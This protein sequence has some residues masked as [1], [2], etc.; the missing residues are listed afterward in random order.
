MFYVQSH[1]VAEYSYC[2]AGE[3]MDSVT[4]MDGGRPLEYVGGVL[5]SEI[6]QGN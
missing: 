5:F 4:W 3:S 2:S 1:A 6:Q